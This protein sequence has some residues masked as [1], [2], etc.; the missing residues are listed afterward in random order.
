MEDSPLG[1]DKWMCAIWM[2]ANCKNGVSSYE[3]H[4]ALGITQ[5]SAWFLMHRIRLAMQS[6]TF[7]KLSGEVEVD[8]TF[9]GGKARNMHKS[10]LE[11]TIKGRGASGKAIVIGLLERGGLVKTKVIPNT[12]KEILHKEVKGV[13]SA[14]TKVSTGNSKTYIYTDGH[15]GY[16]GLDKEYLHGVVDHAVEYVKSNVS[17][18]GIENFWTLLKR[19]IKGTYASM[20]PFHLFRYLDEQSF[21]YN[22]RK[23]DDGDRF[24]EVAANI[25]GKRLTYKRLTGKLRGKNS[26]KQSQD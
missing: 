1:L 13:V 4:R 20:E 16:I 19:C 12:S 25:S 10:R 3:V 26:E 5:K 2:V 18:N 6:S 24:I 8:E 22:H 7:D 14:V 15:K 11:K 17:T 9:I 23:T 21:R